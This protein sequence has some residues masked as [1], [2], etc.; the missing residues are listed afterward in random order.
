[1]C[2]A[3]FHDCRENDLLKQQLKKYI[4][5]MKSL[6]R[7]NGSPAQSTSANGPVDQSAL[8]DYT[9]EAEQ[10]EQKLVQVQFSAFLNSF[11]IESW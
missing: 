1:M 4:G 8:R 10:Y 9:F 3:H 5:T 6:Q 11:Y 7:E 2:F